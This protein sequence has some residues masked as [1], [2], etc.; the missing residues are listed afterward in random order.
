LLLSTIT[1][2]KNDQNTVTDFD[3][4]V[5]GTTAS[6][7]KRQMTWLKENTQI[8][9]EAELIMSL[10]NSNFSTGIS[11]MVTFDDGYIDNY[12]IA[13]PIL[14]KLNIP[15]T[16]F[17]P[18]HTINSRKLGWWDIISYLIKKSSYEAIETSNLIK[19]YI[20]KMIHLPANNTDKLLENLSRKM[21]IPFPDNQSQSNELMTWEHIKELSEN[22]MTIGAHTHTH[23]VLSTLPINEQKHELI[24][25]KNILEEKIEGA[26]HS[27]AYPVGAKHCFTKDT[28]ELVKDCGYK[29]AYSY[30]T[31]ANNI[32]SIIPTE[33][34]RISETEEFSVFKSNLAFSGIFLK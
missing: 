16:F 15:A 24:T 11:T 34:K 21:N 25:S 6:M 18:T 2:L 29:I 5:F 12:R 9:T 30:N 1:V 4:G 22:N 19:K 32:N 23:R 26:I 7:F 17:I 14:K 10:E 8:I 20:Y 27:I 33:I 31:G 3:D 13:F 28:S